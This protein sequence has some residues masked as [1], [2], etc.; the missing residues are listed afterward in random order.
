MPA[1]CTGVGKVLLAFAR[2]E[3]AAAAVAAGLA[4]RAP[5]TITDP[6]RLAEVLAG[7]RD[8]GVAFD[9]EECAAGLACVAAPVFAPDG[10]CLAA[11]SVTG[12]ART[13]PLDRLAPAARTAGL[14]ISRALRDL[15][16][17]R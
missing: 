8:A 17:L 2:P 9:R 7:V 12:P 16:R 1:Y 10:D 5:G 14:G 11:L 15:G 3:V 13:L 4:A 6:A